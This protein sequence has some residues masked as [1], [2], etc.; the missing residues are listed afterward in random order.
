MSF[1]ERRHTRKFCVNFIPNNTTDTDDVTPDDTDNYDVSDFIVDTY[2]FTNY[3][4][5]VSL[6]RIFKQARVLE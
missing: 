6:N 3:K 5:P 1:F 2:T 4:E